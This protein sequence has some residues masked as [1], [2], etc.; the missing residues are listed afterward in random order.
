MENVGDFMTI[1]NILRPFGVVYGHLVNFVVISYIFP[2]GMLRLEK[3]GNLV[4]NTYFFVLTSWHVVRPVAN[5][6]FRVEGQSRPAG[7]VLH[8]PLTSA[9]ILTHEVRVAVGG[10]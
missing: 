2:F 7:V 4:P 10:I 9:Q 8:L 1:W 6:C 3:S 5:L